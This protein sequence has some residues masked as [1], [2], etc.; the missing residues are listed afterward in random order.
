MH[1]NNEESATSLLLPV[2]AS[3]NI[4]GPGL[5]ALSVLNLSQQYFE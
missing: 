2:M 3:L 1:G 5:D 4:L